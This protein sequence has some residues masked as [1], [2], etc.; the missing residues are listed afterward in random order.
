MSQ[1]YLTKS[2]PVLRFSLFAGAITILILSAILAFWISPSLKQKKLAHWIVESGGD[3]SYS[4]QE[5]AAEFFSTADY[6]LLGYWPGVDFVDNLSVIYLRDSVSE[7]SHL[8]H[9]DGVAR[10]TINEFT[11]TDLSPIRNLKRIES[12]VISKSNTIHLN[13]LIQLS[14][15][16][17]LTINNCPLENIQGIANCSKLSFLDLRDTRVKDIKILRRLK[18]L[19][20]LDLS[21]TNVVDIRP[22]EKLGKLNRLKLRGINISSESLHALQTAL[23]NCIIDAD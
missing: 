8:R 7:I 4:A 12:L 11:G 1:P 20:N 22:L 17:Y 18:E 3:I 15:L 10:I 6:G 9:A 16:K 21:N 5:R 19:S 13:D 14:A 23:P 2:K